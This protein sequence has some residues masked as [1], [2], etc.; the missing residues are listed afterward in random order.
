MTAKTDARRSA[1]GQ[2]GALRAASGRLQEAARERRAVC[3]AHRGKLK[4]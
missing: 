1:R 3:R 2:E 4:N